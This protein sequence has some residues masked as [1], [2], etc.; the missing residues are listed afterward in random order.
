MTLNLNKIKKI[1]EKIKKKKNNI[2]KKEQKKPKEELPEEA[3][4]GKES[5]KK[6]EVLKTDLQ[7]QEIELLKREVGD[8]KD[9]IKYNLAYSKRNYENTKKIKRSIAWMSIGGLLKFLLIVA[10][11][12]FAYFYFLPYMTQISA[13]YSEIYQNINR[14]LLIQSNNNT[15]KSK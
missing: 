10:P 7:L 8:L 11:L 6:S 9:L 14:M 15:D 5:E 1:R 13:K 3:K 12:V 4:E 2:D